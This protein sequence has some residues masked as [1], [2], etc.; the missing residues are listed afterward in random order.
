VFLY[1]VLYCDGIKTLDKRLLFA[2]VH[3]CHKMVTIYYN[4]FLFF[5]IFRDIEIVNI[6]Q[7]IAQ[8]I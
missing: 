6:A 5:G 4:D 3:A 8:Y 2:H 1:I 7:N